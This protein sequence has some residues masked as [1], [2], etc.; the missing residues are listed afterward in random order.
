MEVENYEAA[1]KTWRDLSISS[2]LKYTPHEYVLWMDEIM[3]KVS[4]GWCET[5]Y[6]NKED[7]AHARIVVPRQIA[8]NLTKE[9]YDA[10]VNELMQKEK[11]FKMKRKLKNL[12][13]DF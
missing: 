5:E 8:L 11:V 4:A 3:D 1:R 2:W 9:D 7:A 6:V 12:E 13:K 10:Y